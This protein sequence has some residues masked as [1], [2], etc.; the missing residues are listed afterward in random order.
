MRIISRARSGLKRLLPPIADIRCIRS[1]P[2]RSRNKAPDLCPA[3]V[4]LVGPYYGEPEFVWRSNQRVGRH[5]DPLAIKSH[6][7]ISTLC[8]PIHILDALTVS[9]GAARP[10]PACKAVEPLLERRVRIF[11]IEVA[12]DSQLGNK[13]KRQ[14]RADNAEVDRS[15]S[16]ISH[17]KFGHV[18]QALWP[19]ADQKP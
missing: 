11:S 7:I 18:G 10:S 1:L 19:E 3:L 12:G 8:I 2:A 16:E 17:A 9:D 6:S 13:Q 4:I 14:C 15:C 5:L